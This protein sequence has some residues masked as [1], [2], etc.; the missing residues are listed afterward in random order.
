MIRITTFIILTFIVFS[1]AFFLK[2]PEQEDLPPLLLTHDKGTLP[3]FHRAFESQAK[4]A[5]KATGIRFTA[6][7]SHT[8]DLFISRT[9][10]NL[11]TR[12]APAL[13]SWWHGDRVRDLV[14]KNLVT[15]LSELWERHA[16]YYPP[17]IRQSY[18]HENKVYGFPYSIEYWPIWY[19]KKIFERL[20]L[21]IPETWEDFIKICET[22]KKN[23]ITP[24]LSSLQHSWYATIW[25]SQLLMGE[26]P[27]YYLQFCR[28]CF[29]DQ[30]V[31]KAMT[32]WQDMIKKEYFTSTSTRMFTN[33]GHL[34]KEEAFGMVLCGSW[35]PSAILMAQGV[36]EE[37]IGVFILPSHNPD[38]RVSL[39]MET[40][41]IFVAANNPQR[42]KA[43]IIADW[44]MGPEGS[45]EFSKALNTFS[46]NS[47][48]DTSHLPEFRQKFLKQLDNQKPM[49][50]PRFWETAPGEILQPVT[51]ILARFMMNPDNLEE[52]LEQLHL[53]QKQAPGE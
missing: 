39:M 9:V 35:Y 18:T 46:A 13:F 3:K 48:V 44:W 25:F 19:N 47:H 20:D 16:E 52:T 31:R 43:T 11:P 34:W 17:S 30:K 23:G 10:A 4:K 45:L 26:D 36:A 50:L 51:D 6:V 29:K 22:L 1:F 2:S 49:V 14:E 28:N 32:I 40:G 12:E 41:A 27:D 37:N 33:G 53:L 21:E 15:D 8:T 7:S 38:A 42:D 5:E 24:I